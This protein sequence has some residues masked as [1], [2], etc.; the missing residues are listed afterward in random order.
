MRIENKKGEGVLF[1]LRARGFQGLRI[2]FTIERTEFA[3]SPKR[4]SRLLR[5][6]NS[7]LIIEYKEIG[8]QRQ[9]IK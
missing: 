1:V 8:F 7:H 3:L 5:D 9:A 4:D 2:P 6:G